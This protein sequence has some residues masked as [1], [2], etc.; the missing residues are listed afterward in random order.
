MTLDLDT[1]SEKELKELKTKVE[2]ALSTLDSRRLAEARKA[3][4]DAAAMHGFNL[5]DLVGGKAPKAKS[6]P[7][8]RNP[9]NASQTWSGRGRQP[10]WIKEGLAAG[11]P[12]SSFAI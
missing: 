10:A 7:K 12:M 2:R 11:K 6:A 9:A 4:E 1:L 3:A 8:Y 5:A